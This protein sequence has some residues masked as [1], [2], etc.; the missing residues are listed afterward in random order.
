MNKCQMRENKNFEFI[1]LNSSATREIKDHVQNSILCLIH[2]PENG[3]Q[4]VMTWEKFSKTYHSVPKKI[5]L[6]PSLKLY[7]YLIKEEFLNNEDSIDLAPEKAIEVIERFGEA[8]IN[9][10]KTVQEQQKVILKLKK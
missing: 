7:K 4:K 5:M 1:V 10:T 2:D 6:D 3:E 8:I 9:L